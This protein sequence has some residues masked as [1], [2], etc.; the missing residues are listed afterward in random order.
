MHLLGTNQHKTKQGET[1]CTLLVLLGTTASSTHTKGSL[2][3]IVDPPLQACQGTY[4][5]YTSTQTSSAQFLETDLAG[6]LADA[7]SFIG[8]FAELRDQT[9]CGMR[10]DGTHYTSNI[11][12]GKGNTKLGWLAIGLLWFGENMI[13]EHFHRL[14]EEEELGHGVGDLPTPQGY[15]TSERESSL[16]S[17][18]LHGSNGGAQFQ[19]E[20]TSRRGLNLDFYHFHW[21]K[22]NVGKEFGRR[23]TGEVDQSTVLG[24]ILLSSQVLIHVL[25]DFIKPKLAETL[26]R[27]ADEGWRPSFPDSIRSFFGDQGPK[28]REE[29]LVLRGVDLHVAFHNIQRTYEGVG[30]TATQNTANHAFYVVRCVVDMRMRLS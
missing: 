7:F 14:L 25:E 8:G 22:R 29:T 5:Q 2:K 9:V 12:R 3:G 19:G 6:D 23:R 24:G 20:G 4:H 27:L 18:F 21:A 13:I 30:E 26:H 11:T 17:S 16:R 28:A 1:Y 15:D 10:Y